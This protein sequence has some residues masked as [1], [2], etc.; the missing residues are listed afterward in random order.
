MNSRGAGPAVLLVDD[1]RDALDA[2]SQA[3][4]AERYRVDTARDPRDALE[5]LER[6]SYDAAVVDLKMPGMSGLDVLRAMR[7]LDPD[8]A[9]V[10]VTGYATVETAVE[11]MKDGASDYLQK[12]FT[13]DELRLAVRRAI[14]RQELVREN[15]ALR[16]RLGAQREA[17]ALIGESAPMREVRRLIARV[18]EGEATVLV[19]GETGTGKELAAR[20]IH[21]LSRRAAQ[22]FIA[23]DCAAVPGELLESEFFGHEKGAFT[24][25]IRRRKGS[26]ELA[27]GG[28]LFLDEIGTMSVE[29]QAKLLRVLQEREIQPVGSERKIAIDVRVIAATNR[30][31]REA[32]RQGGFRED[33]YYR[34]NVI[35]LRLPP[36]R[37]RPDDI[38]LLVDHFIAKHGPKLA[39]RIES[40]DPAALAALAAAPWPGNVRELESAVERAMT[41]VDGPVL[42]AGAFGCLGEEPRGTVE[43][44]SAAP[45][46]DGGTP[47][48][49]APL[50]PLADVERDYI[51]QVLHATRWNRREASRILG[52]ST[53][54]LWRKINGRAA[55]D[56]RE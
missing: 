36:L 39:R 4:A 54:T 46:R 48:D 52:I 11:A 56:S 43:T 9:V 19:T 28:T 23:V 6:G 32:V 25:A 49:A 7:R 50:P 16:E 45:A 10:M 30:N 55:E 12:P 53:V 35:P 41:L 2:C 29:L 33:L 14:D 27:H 42:D 17:P 38:P 1:E 13:P 8:V 21:A 40:V 51:M 20:A 22:P 24:G 18:A 44:S 15:Q 26:F 34:L 3:L 37:E 47:R 31:L 5:K